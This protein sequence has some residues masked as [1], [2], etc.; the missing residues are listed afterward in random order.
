MKYER[1]LQLFGR[2]NRY[3]TSPPRQP[4]QL[5]L[6]PRHAH[7]LRRDARARRQQRQLRL[8][9]LRADD[10]EVTPRGPG[11][12][13]HLVAS[14]IGALIYPFLFRTATMHEFDLDDAAYAAFVRERKALIS[15][16]V[17]GWLLRGS[18]A[19]G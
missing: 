13:G 3:R 19:D 11:V 5:H 1:M 9:C 15:A 12:V 16:R 17:G 8:P 14:L 2:P 7:L 10:P 4:Q 6:R 18:D